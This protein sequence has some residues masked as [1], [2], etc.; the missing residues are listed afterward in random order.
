MAV[1]LKSLLDRIYE[2]DVVK[3]EGKEYPLRAWWIA[4]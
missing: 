2:H 3:I 4:S 1:A